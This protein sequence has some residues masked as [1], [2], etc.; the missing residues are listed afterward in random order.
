MSAVVLIVLLEVMGEVSLKVR[1]PGTVWPQKAESQPA[2]PLNHH[3]IR[4]LSQS[5]WLHGDSGE[6]QSVLLTG[7]PGDLSGMVM[8]KPFIN[9]ERAG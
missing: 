7:A 5:E 3:G 4:P 1:P 9:C 2:L 8:S 6:C